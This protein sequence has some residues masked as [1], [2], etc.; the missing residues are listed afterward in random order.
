MIRCGDKRIIKEAKKRFESLRKGKRVDPDTRSI[1]LAAVALT[2]GV[3]D[4][5]TL[6]GMYKA[7]TL[8]EERDRIGAALGDFQDTKILNMVCDFALSSH[9]RIQDTVSI[10]TSVAINPTGRDIWMK[11]IKSNWKTLISRYG[12]GGFTLSRL[13]KGI[14]G[15][16]EEKH[17]REF[18][19][20]FKT[21][22]APGAKRSIDQ[23]LERIESNIAWRK[24]DSKKISKLLNS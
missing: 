19:S 20:F 23:V 5:N 16:S 22:E 10:L 13:V 2:G 17:L 6:V 1:I 9:V 11:S 3:K 24:R 14:S 4:Y 18:K 15:S 12:G 21:H 7:E 8:H